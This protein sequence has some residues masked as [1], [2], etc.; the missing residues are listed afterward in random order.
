MS[1]RD[2]TSAAA[3]KAERL[4][5]WLAGQVDGTPELWA[6]GNSAGDLELLSLADHPV[7]IGRRAGRS[8]S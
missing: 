1:S 7:W 6:Y 8:R 2:G 3:V 4:R 5:D